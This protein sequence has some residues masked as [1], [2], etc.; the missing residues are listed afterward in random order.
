MYAY[1]VL[2]SGYRYDLSDEEAHEL[3]RRAIYHATFRDAS[4]GGI[5]RGTSFFFHSNESVIIL[6]LLV[7]HI[8]STG[9][10]KISEQDC[11]ELHYKYEETKNA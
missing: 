11:N 6:A 10:V 1:G 7:Y 9:W 8:M 2:D 5:I 4:S 3:G